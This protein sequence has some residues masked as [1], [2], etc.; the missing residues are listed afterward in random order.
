MRVISSM[1]GGLA[2]ALSV[3][4]I[5]ELLKKVDPSAPRLDLLRKQAAF[6]IADRVNNGSTDAGKLKGLCA[7][8]DI[9]GNTL[10][11]SL[12][13]AAGKRAIPVGS[14]LGLG[15]GAGAIT[16]PSK[17]GLN[18]W[19]TGGTRKRKLMTM[20]LYLIGG[21][22]AASVSRCFNKK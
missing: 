8:G 4:L 17:L 11:F 21:L 6:K 20:G 13:A 16:L 3:R 12:T 2:G 1:A 15:M 5:Q 22:V 9:I 19:F 10:Y 14:I 7:A 18:S